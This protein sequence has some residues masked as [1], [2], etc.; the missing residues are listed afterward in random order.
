MNF[1]TVNEHR[2]TLALFATAGALGCALLLMRVLP[3]RRENAALRDRRLALDQELA[4]YQSRNALD[5]LPDQVRRQQNAHQR[6]L[7]H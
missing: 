7:Q 2:W 4:P 5:P 3:L 1:S 6:L